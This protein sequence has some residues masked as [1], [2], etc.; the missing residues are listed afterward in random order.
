MKKVDFRALGMA[1]ALTGSVLL[2][3]VLSTLLVK[4]VNPVVTAILLIVVL[5]VFFYFVFKD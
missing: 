4:Y 5:V 3:A 2:G 1:L